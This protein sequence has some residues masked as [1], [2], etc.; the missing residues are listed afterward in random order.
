M[1]VSSKGNRAAMGGLSLSLLQSLQ[2]PPALARG[3]GEFIS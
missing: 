2:A 1:V 3:G